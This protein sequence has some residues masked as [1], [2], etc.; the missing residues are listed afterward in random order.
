MRSRRGFTLVELLVVIAII[1]ILAAILFPVFA[2]AKRSAQIAVCQS[3]LKQWGAAALMYIDDNAGRFPF[4]GANR[5]YP[6][7]RG[8]PLFKL[9][10]SP[11]AYDALAKYVRK[12]DN[13]KWCP[14]EKAI[15]QRMH[16]EWIDSAGW[17]YYYYCGHGGNPYGAA[18]PAAML[19]GYRASDV[20]STLKK[21]LIAE[22]ISYAHS[23]DGA[24]TQECTCNFAYCDGHVKLVVRRY[25]EF[26]A[27]AY[28]GRDGSLP[29]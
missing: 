18:Y 9:G 25:R 14:V 13:I 8:G 3:N 28:T 6:H 10:G 29:H 7:P 5:W 23:P 27:Y 15:L 2:R 4:A 19:C 24:Q 20:T 12:A 1:A 11:T 17:G 22:L 16:P 21:P 26:E